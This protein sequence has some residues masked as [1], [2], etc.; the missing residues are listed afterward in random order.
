MGT[1]TEGTLGQWHM[2]LSSGKAGTLQ[3]VFAA[4]R[5]DRRRPIAAVPAAA[6]PCRASGEAAPVVCP[7][8]PVPF[9]ASLGRVDLRRRPSCSDGPSGLEARERLLA[10]VSR[11]AWFVQCQ[12]GGAVALYLMLRPPRVVRVGRSL[13]RG[14]A[15]RLGSGGESGFDVL[16]V[17]P[18]L[19]G[20]KSHDRRGRSS[21]ARR[22]TCRPFA[23]DNRSFGPAAVDP[24]LARA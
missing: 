7:S 15:K 6:V 21:E 5:T 2:A 20:T 10:Q 13:N 9:T 11:P 19:P 23:L 17:T 1:G 22:A 24:S 14:E 18:P 4:V 16:P 3:Y 12:D 8:G